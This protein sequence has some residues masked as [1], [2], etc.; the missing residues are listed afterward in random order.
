[1]YL[2]KIVIVLLA[3]SVAAILGLGLR[4]MMHNGDMATS[5]KLMRLRVGV[6][7]IVIGL[8]MT[9]LYIFS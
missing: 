3:L 5:Q 7:F 2:M 1:M 8:V 4:N 9:T 6:Q